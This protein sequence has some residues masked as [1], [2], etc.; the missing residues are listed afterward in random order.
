MNND[1]LS[2]IVRDIVSEEWDK[3]VEIKSTGEHAD[4]TI[5]QIKKEMEALKGKTPFNREQFSELMFALRAKQGWKKGK[6]ATKES[7]T[8][9]KANLKQIIRTE[10]STLLSENTNTLDRAYKVYSSSLTSFREIAIKLKDNKL[11]KFWRE[12][13]KLHEKITK[14]LDA[15]YEGAL[16]ESLSDWNEDVLPRALHSQLEHGEEALNALV[17]NT[18][19]DKELIKFLKAHQKL[20]VMVSKHLHREYPDWEKR[21]DEDIRNSK[22]SKAELVKALKKFKK[23]AKVHYFPLSGGNYVMVGPK[24]V[25]T[26]DKEAVNVQIR[27]IGTYDADNPNQVSVGIELNN[28]HEATWNGTEFEI[29]DLGCPLLLGKG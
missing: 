24:G 16:S 11:Q 9:N 27:K 28:G 3:D 25:Q 10:L 12:L 26:K 6:G 2:D 19:N 15:N 14:H 18:R 29:D 1:K 7:I 23:G 22:K 8:M 21:M 17:K 20:G 13:D 4:K 5:A